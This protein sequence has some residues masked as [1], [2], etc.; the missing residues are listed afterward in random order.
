VVDLASKYAV[1]KEQVFYRF[2]QT[3]DIVPLSGTTSEQHMQDDL[4]VSES[5]IPLTQSEVESIKQLIS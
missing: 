2:V 1:T 5:T 3:Q 4:V